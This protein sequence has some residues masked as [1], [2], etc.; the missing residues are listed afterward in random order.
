MYEVAFFHAKLNDAAGQ[1]AR[2]PVFRNLDFALYGVV[3]S[4]ERK[5]ADESDNGND[6]NEADDGK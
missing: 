6:E 3:S 5:E 1:L 4:V 2:Y